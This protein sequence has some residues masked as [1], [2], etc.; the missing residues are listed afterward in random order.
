[1]ITTT[2]DEMLEA[3][4][5]AALSQDT[6]TQNSAIVFGEVSNLTIGANGNMA[7]E[8]RSSVG[9]MN[10]VSDLFDP[11]PAH[12]ERPLKD[13]YIEHAERSAIYQAASLG[14]PTGGGIMISPWAA[15]VDCARAIIHSG[16]KHLVVHQPM[17]VATPE[18]WMEQVALGHQLLAE[19]GVQIHRYNGKLASAN[20]ILF[21]GNP[22]QP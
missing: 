2:Y 9:M 13:T 16:I 1:M 4:R 14:I 15:C 12:N 10:H 7:F 11:T 22:F 21:N 18:R 19:A 3:Y 17:M 20:E 6:S 8:C 5:I